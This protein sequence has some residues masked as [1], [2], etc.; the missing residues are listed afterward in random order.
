[1]NIN[2]FARLPYHLTRITE[3]MVRPL[4]SQFMGVTLRYDLIPLLTGVLILV[5]GLFI[6]GMLSQ[7]RMIVSDYTALAQTG[8]LF[9]SGGLAE[10]V[11][12]AGLLFVIAVFLRWILPFFGIG[13]TNKW[14]RFLFTV[15]EP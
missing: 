15:T 9:S 2:P 1:M 10:T 7:L 13:Y 3:P 6:A 14:F 8:R 12:L 5:T 4:R 11:R